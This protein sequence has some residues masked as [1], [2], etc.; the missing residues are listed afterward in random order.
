MRILPK[1]C[2]CRALETHFF[3]LLL[4]L[5][6][7]LLHHDP[8]LKALCVPVLFSSFLC[9]FLSHS[10]SKLKQKSKNS[11]KL[12]SSFFKKKPITH[13]PPHLLL[14]TSKEIPTKDQQHAVR[15]RII[16]AHRRSRREENVAVFSRFRLRRCSGHVFDDD[17]YE[18][19]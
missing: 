10:F 12:K 18:R 5:L 17:D 16:L 15:V 1:L 3:F 2:S 7:L 9:R 14:F 6:L 8:S 13:K 11:K 4:L 19:G